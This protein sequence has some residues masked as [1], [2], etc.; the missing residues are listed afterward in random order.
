MFVG[1]VFYTVF[2]CL[3]ASLSTTFVELYD[4][5]YLEAGPAYL[6][7]GL[8]GILAA[9]ATGKLLNVDYQRTAK[10]HGL[11]VNRRSGDDLSGFPIERARLRSAV[12]L[13]VVSTA[14]VIGYGWSLDRKVV[15]HFRSSS[16][17]KP[18]LS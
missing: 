7:A 2:G 15:G 6:P 14:A 12:P 16:Q 5:N 18:G 8:G 17:I 11:E 10:K 4:L 13:A 1:G 3:A 9:Y